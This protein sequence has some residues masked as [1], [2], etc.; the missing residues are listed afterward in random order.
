MRFPSSW[1]GHMILEDV[2]KLASK[3]Q[4]EMLMDQQ[5]RLLREN[6]RRKAIAALYDTPKQFNWHIVEFKL[7]SSQLDAGVLAQL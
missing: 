6:I 5:H 2:H 1:V 4:L 7:R 3:W